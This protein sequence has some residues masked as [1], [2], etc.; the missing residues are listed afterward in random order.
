MTYDSTTTPATPYY[1]FVRDRMATSAVLQSLVNIYTDQFNEG[2]ALNAARYNNIV[3]NWSLL[4]D[5]TI[6]D[7]D[8]A[9]DSSNGRFG[10]AIDNLDVALTE[11]SSL[12]AGEKVE[13]LASLLA[14]S[15]EISTLLTKVSDLE[16]AFTTYSSGLDAS[17]SSATADLGTYQTESEAGLSQLLT[18]YNEM[19]LLV[20][21]IGTEYANDLSAH[22]ASYTEQLAFL[23]MDYSSH[24]ATARAYL[25]DLGV[26]ELARINEAYD[27]RLAEVAQNLLNRGFYSAAL[28]GAERERVG[29]ERSE[30]ITALN[31]RLARE[32]LENEHK[33]YEQGRAMRTTTMEGLERVQ[34]LRTALLHWK[35]Q[36]E[37]RL[38]S[39]LASAQSKIVEGI[40]RRFS[41]G[42]DVSQLIVQQRTA[43]L[44]AQRSQLAARSAVVDSQLRAAQARTEVMSRLAAFSMETAMNSVRTAFDANAQE[45]KLIQYQIDSQNNLIVGLFAFEEKRSDEYPSMDVLA[46][47]CMGLGDSAATSWVSP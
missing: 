14:V 19:V 38:E 42:R 24:A 13:A 3:A 26:T 12:I 6:K 15:Q 23:S 44:E 36:V 47:L 27:A 18:N 34:Q 10:L 31:D 25:T 41:A 29:R 17:I 40:D 1:N 30:Q 11:V 9:G 39:E 20:R 35:E 21:S 2:R 37:S 43:R 8:A 7:L 28:L 46:R 16:T 4:I 45:M 5:A 22:V 32:N 33:L